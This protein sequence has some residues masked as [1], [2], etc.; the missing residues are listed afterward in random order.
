MKKK[1]IRSDH[2]VNRFI[3]LHYGVKKKQLDQ[4]IWI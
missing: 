2:V 4:I 1:T 3:W